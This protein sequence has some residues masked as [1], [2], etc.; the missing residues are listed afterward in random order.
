LCLDPGITLLIGWRGGN[1][2]PK[3]RLALRAPLS[4]RA[5]WSYLLFDRL[6]VV[7]E[8]PAIRA[9]AAVPA[10][11]RLLYPLDPAFPAQVDG[12]GHRFEP[13]DLGKSPPLQLA[14]T[15]LLHPAA[16]WAVAATA[17]RAATWTTPSI[18]LFV[19]LWMGPSRDGHPLF[20]IHISGTRRRGQAQG[21]V[22]LR[23]PHSL[24]LSPRSLPALST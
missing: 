8:H 14:A 24:R 20:Y 12:A 22:V 6:H 16:A 5:S 17:N 13:D 19:P 11:F 9:A 4:T 2:A 18:H 3:H 7:A 23:G 21:T 15:F 10:Q 1:N